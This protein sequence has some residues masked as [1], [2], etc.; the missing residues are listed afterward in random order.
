V[1]DRRCSEWLGRWL[2]INWPDL[3]RVLIPGCC[4]PVSPRTCMC[5]LVGHSSVIGQRRIRK[6][7]NLGNAPWEH[8]WCMYDFLGT[9]MVH[10]EFLGNTHGACRFLGNAHGTC[11]HS[12]TAF[13]LRHQ[14]GHPHTSLLPTK[15]LFFFT[16]FISLIVSE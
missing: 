12:E 8:A 14:R 1:V 2:H 9:R 16:S 5:R 10:V 4:D 11:R 6:F 3:L 7:D 13:T 15:T